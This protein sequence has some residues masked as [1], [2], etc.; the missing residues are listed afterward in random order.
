MTEANESLQICYL[1]LRIIVRKTIP[2]QDFALLRFIAVFK[3]FRDSKT[4]VE[5]D[6]EW[7]KII[8]WMRE[9]CLDK[10]W[11]FVHLKLTYKNL[12]YK[13]LGKKLIILY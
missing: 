2:A 4:N 10:Y 5:T 13:D 6:R 11:L 1:L 7:D 9:V 12:N 8:N 3:E